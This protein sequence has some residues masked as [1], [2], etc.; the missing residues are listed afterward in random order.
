MIKYFR[1]LFL[2]FCVSGPGAICFGAGSLFETISVGTSSAVVGTTTIHNA[3]WAEAAKVGW[4]E[5]SYIF[6]SGSSSVTLYYRY[7][8]GTATSS[9]GRKAID[10][11]SFK[12]KNIDDMTRVN[13]LCVGGVGSV[14]VTYSRS[15]RDNN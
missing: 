7:D 6:D 2:L 1:F 11:E 5:G 13:F 3:E 10:R 12:L 9:A 8:G 4:V 15:R 14:T